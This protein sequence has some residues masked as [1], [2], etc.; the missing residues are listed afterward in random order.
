MKSFILTLSFV[1]SSLLFN[2]SISA[3]EISIYRVE[4]QISGEVKFESYDF[5]QYSKSIVIRDRDTEEWL[6]TYSEESDGK[7]AELKNPFGKISTITDFPLSHIRP[8]KIIRGKLSMRNL[9]GET[10]EFSIFATAKLE[11]DQLGKPLTV[12]TMVGQNNPI[13]YR[14]TVVFSDNY[15]F[16]NWAEN[17]LMVNDEIVDHE[18]ITRIQ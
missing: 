13:S 2:T 11:R 15:Y 1:F 9:K 6:G 16:P 7:K 17:Q 5:D 8:G 14:S 4:N 18:T 3:Q 10:L 12:V